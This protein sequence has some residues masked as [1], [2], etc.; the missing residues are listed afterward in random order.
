MNRVENAYKNYYAILDGEYDLERV[1]EFERPGIDVVLSGKLER[2]QRR[3]RDRTKSCY[4]FL[5]MIQSV[6]KLIMRS[7]PRYYLGGKTLFKEDFR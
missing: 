7:L 6:N 5:T 4:I 3:I 2:Q 1:Q